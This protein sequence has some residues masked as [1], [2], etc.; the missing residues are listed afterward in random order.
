MTI[1][2]DDFPVSVKG[3]DDEQ[4]AEVLLSVV[5]RGHRGFIQMQARQGDHFAYGAQRSLVD[6][7]YKGLEISGFDSVKAS[8]NSVA[9]S[10]DIFGVNLNTTTDGISTCR[11]D[12]RK[13]EDF[14]TCVE[15]AVEAWGERNGYALNYMPE[16]KPFPKAEGAEDRSLQQ[17]LDSPTYDG[18]ELD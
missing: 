4:T 9:S 12:G 16:G 8:T 15:Y 17:M 13:F 6:E 7:V 11:G 1:L 5:N 2:K 14:V 18:Y 3:T 10:P